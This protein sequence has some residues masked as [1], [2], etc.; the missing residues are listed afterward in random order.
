MDAPGSRERHEAE[1]DVPRAVSKPNT[2]AALTVLIA[3]CFVVVNC[4]DL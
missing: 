1:F 4:S 3:K 2:V